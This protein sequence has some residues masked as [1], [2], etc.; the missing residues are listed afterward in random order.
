[1]AWNKYVDAVNLIQRQ[2]W[3]SR[4]M[5][6]LGVQSVF[7]ATQMMPSTQTMLQ[8]T[9]AFLGTFREKIW[10]GPVKYKNVPKITKIEGYNTRFRNFP[11]SEIRMP[12]DA[13]QGH[14][15]SLE[16]SH[17]AWK[18]HVDAFTFISRQFWVSQEMNK[19]GIHR[20]FDT[21]QMVP[22]TR[23]TLQVTLA[24]LGMFWEKI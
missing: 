21:R 15:R 3:I 22:S 13:S 1:M 10:P 5:N 14:G 24:L 20:L 17:V 2:F 8:V 16:K 19:C 7:K 18:E 12:R 9:S 4:E 23:A 11:R 6:K